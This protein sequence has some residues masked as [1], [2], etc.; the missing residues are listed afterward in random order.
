MRKAL[1]VYPEF[2][3]SYWSHKYALQFIGR[4]AVLPPLGLLTVAGLF[5]SDYELRLSDMNVQELTDEDLLWA[6]YVFISAMVVQRDSFSQVVQRCKQFK[7]PVV[8]GGPFI[9]SFWEEVPGVDHYLLGEIEQTFPAFLSDLAA[10][11]AAAFYRPSLDWK[12]EDLRPAIS[13]APLPRYDLINLKDYSDMAVQFSRGCPFDCEFCDITKMNGRVP[14]TK[15]DQQILAELNNL[16]DWGWRGDVFF[17]DDNFIGNAREALRL[18]PLVAAW[19][20]ERGRPFGFY[21]QASVNLAEKPELMEA[22]VQAGFY[23]VFMGLETP[24]PKALQQTNKK[25]NTKEGVPDYLLSAVKRVQAQGMEVTAG[26]ILGLDGDDESS[27]DAQIDFIQRAGIPSAMVGLLSAIKGTGLYQRLEREGRLLAGKSNG[28]NV[29]AALNFIPQLDHKVL[30]AGYKRVLRTLYQPSLRNYFARCYTYLDNWKQRNLSQDSGFEMR[31]LRAI[32]KSVKRQVFSRQGPAYLKFMAKVIFNFPG[33]FG[34]AVRLA[35]IG[36]HYE[37]VTRQQLMTD[38]F[39]ELLET[40]GSRL[41]GLSLQGD[42]LVHLQES[43]EMLKMRYNAISV[44][45]RESLNEA[46]QTFTNEMRQL[47]QDWPMELQLAA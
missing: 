20:K 17:V 30:L 23:M 31:D 16:Y 18:L 11:R 25:H 1:L 13:L 26:F 12:G 21:T 7:I 33:K 22:M 39:R 36:Y 37:R 2:P 3:P 32:L 8:A 5:P 40:E 9:T 27:F 47:S 44:D 35:I 43:F 29:S 38:E 24:N 14:R 34:D 42:I 46:I 10:G 15:S 19:Q 45:F 28:N 41:R 6:D 4:K